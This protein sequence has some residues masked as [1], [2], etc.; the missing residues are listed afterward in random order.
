MTKLE[1]SKH[2]ITQNIWDSEKNIYFNVTLGISLYKVCGN[3]SC[4]KNYGFSVNSFVLREARKL[5]DTVNS[6]LIRTC[7]RRFDSFWCFP[8]AYTVIT[9]YNT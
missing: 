9:L 5:W 1:Q 3:K 8:L 4:F 7:V 2:T 6:S